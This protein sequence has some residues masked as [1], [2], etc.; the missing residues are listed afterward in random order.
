MQEG[1]VWGWRRVG[2]G[3]EGREKGAKHA[4]AIIALDG[5]GWHIERPGGGQA[6]ATTPLHTHAVVHRGLQWASQSV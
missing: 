1:E 6:Y 3:G 5:S 4:G 2:G